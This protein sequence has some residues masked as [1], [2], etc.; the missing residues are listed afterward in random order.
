[1]IDPIESRQVL[2]VGRTRV[3]TTLARR[4]GTAGWCVQEY[5]HDESGPAI[6]AEQPV[7]AVVFDP[8]LIDDDS[9]PNP[10]AAAQQ[11]LSLIDSLRGRLRPPESGGA[12]IV[13]LTGRDG[14]G[15]PDRPAASAANGA[16]VAA[17]R[18]LALALAP[19][20]ATVNVVAALPPVGSSLRSRPTPAGSHLRNPV[21]LLPTEVTVGDI[22][23]T[24]AFFLDPR[25][26]YLTGQVLY[27]CG[28]A[29][30]LSSLSV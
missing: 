10:G 23:S 7:D 28:G 13:I 22:A 14:L 8:G 21:E 17:A 26:G 6:A 25:S 27:C 9:E 16:L 18:S 1:M 20:G 15:W 29:S 11:F 3:S 24:A 2:L 30:L 19:V 4:L 12:R 5:G